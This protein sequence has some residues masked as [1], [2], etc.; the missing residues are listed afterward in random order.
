MNTFSLRLPK[1]LR[2]DLA[3][4]AEQE[5][6]SVNQF[7]AQAVAEKV[8]VLKQADKI[9]YYRAQPPVTREAFVGVLDKA[10]KRKVRKGD[11]IK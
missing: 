3:E 11:E 6:I 10:K 8:V 4:L 2:K 7:I 1:S 5:G 9:A